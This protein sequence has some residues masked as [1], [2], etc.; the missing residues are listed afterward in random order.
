MGIKVQQKSHTIT[1]FAEKCIYD[2]LFSPVKLNLSQT[3]EK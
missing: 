3:I 2:R 1:P